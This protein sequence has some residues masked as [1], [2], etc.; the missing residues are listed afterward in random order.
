M[1]A[2]F[3][4]RF[5]S[6]V[7]FRLLPDACWE[8]TASTDTSGYGLFGLASSRMRGA[9]RI[10]FE[11]WNKIKPKGLVL[12]KC[13]N[14]LC[15]NPKHLYDGSRYQNNMDTLNSGKGPNKLTKEQALEIKEKAKT[16]TQ[17][18]LAKEYGVTQSNVSRIV[19]NKYT[20][21]NT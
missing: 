8:W 11:L 2:T 1:S 12:H 13:N 17:T 18:Q 16:Q 20:F 7:N 6:K 14:P 4:E 19:N 9:H 21:F 15:V 10:A 3:E 5:W